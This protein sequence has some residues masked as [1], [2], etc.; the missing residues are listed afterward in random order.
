MQERV[1]LLL[2]FFLVKILTKICQ[3]LERRKSERR[4]RKRSEHI[5]LEANH[6]WRRYKDKNFFVD[7]YYCLAIAHCQFCD[8][9]R[10][11]NRDGL[12]MP[13]LLA[14]SKLALSVCISI[15]SG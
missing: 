5:A 6:P 7:I 15:V 12:R 9:T 10:V 3:F 14:P 11:I 13:R 8:K 1:Y 4:S 2:A